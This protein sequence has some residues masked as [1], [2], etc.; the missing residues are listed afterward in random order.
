MDRAAFARREQAAAKN[1]REGEVS[2]E[3]TIDHRSRL[4]VTVSYAVYAKS[5]EKFPNC[6][7]PSAGYCE[8]GVSVVTVTRAD[9]PIRSDF[10]LPGDKSISHRRALFSLLCSDTVQLENFGT[11]EDC[12][13]SLKCI[14]QLGKVVRWKGDTVTIEQGALP[15]V[16][17]LDCGNSGTTARLMFGLLAGLPGKWTITGD[18]SLSRRPMERVAEPLRQ[19]GAKINLLSGHLPATIEGRRL[20]GIIYD[21]PVAS[22]QVKSAV[23][24]AGL[25]AEGETRYRERRQTRDH[26]ERILGSKRDDSGWIT[27]QPGQNHP[28]SDRLSGTIPADP[29]TATFWTIAALM[30]PDSEIRMPHILANPL[31]NVQLAIL[32]NAGARI[33]VSELAECGGESTATV[34]V[35]H[36]RVPPVRIHSENSASVIDEIPALAVLATHCDGLSEFRDVGELR[37]KESDRIDLISEGLSRM[38]ARV[39]SWQ[40]GFSV[41]GIT[42]LHGARIRTAGDH[43]IVMSLAIAGLCADGETTLENAESSAVSYPE[44]WKELARVA[45][46]CVTLHE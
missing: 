34:T 43:R 28:T 33:E 26:T 32:K 13:S 15:A 39:E 37:L 41:R 46:N 40:D 12:E 29:S 2:T 36:S 11:G 21:S 25:T 1:S 10:D 23:L 31:R 22:A 24:L 6:N 9:G 19:M 20:R 8:N 38:G 18:E 27:V 42:R 30:L 7:A 14:A 5:T 17:D 44:F 35:S 3:F 4:K 16:A 45:P